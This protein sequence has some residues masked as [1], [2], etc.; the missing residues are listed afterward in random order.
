MDR[1]KKGMND[2]VKI[3]VPDSREYFQPHTVVFQLAWGN[4]V[5]SAIHCDFVPARHQSGG[6][7]F[8]EGFESAVAGWNATRSENN[9]AHKPEKPTRYTSRLPDSLHS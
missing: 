4:V 9:D 6:E 3:F 8:G 2:G 7:M 1:G 5:C